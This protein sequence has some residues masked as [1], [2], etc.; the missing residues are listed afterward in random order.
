MKIV[1]SEMIKIRLELSALQSDSEISY[2]NMSFENSNETL[3]EN[4][5][6]RETNNFDNGPFSIK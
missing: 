5:E 3:F 6:A 1:K 4:G 2:L